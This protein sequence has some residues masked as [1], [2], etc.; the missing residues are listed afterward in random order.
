MQRIEYSIYKPYQGKGGMAK[1]SFSQKNN[2]FFLEMA[3]EK[4]DEEKRFDYDKKVNFKLELNDLGDILLVLN[5]QKAGLGALK[6]G[7]WGGLYHK[8]KDSSSFM[9]F[10]VLYEKDTDTPR[11]LALGLG[12]T[13]NNE[14]NKVSIGVSFAE[15]AILLEF[16]RSYLP[17]MFVTESDVTAKPDTSSKEKPK[18]VKKA[19]EKEGSTSS[20]KAGQDDDIPF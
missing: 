16:I 15:A 4:P 19:T 11:G 6:E 20:V 9:N 18:T 13:Q 3:P 7:K 14:T 12:R 8:G 5:R 2:C 17:N 1:I 10:S